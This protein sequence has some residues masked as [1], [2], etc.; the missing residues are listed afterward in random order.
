MVKGHSSLLQS[1]IKTAIDVSKNNI[2]YFNYI[3][4]NEQMLFIVFYCFFSIYSNHAQK[5]LETLQSWFLIDEKEQT[6]KSM[7]DYK[8]PLN[9]ILPWASSEF[10]QNIAK[11]INAK[12]F[13]ISLQ[14]NFVKSN[15]SRGNS[16]RDWTTIAEI[17]N[18]FKSVAQNLGKSYK[19]MIKL[20]I[21]ISIIAQCLSYFIKILEKNTDSIIS[22]S[23][24]ETLKM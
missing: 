16:K 19:V 3:E 13:R 24:Q 17:S 11:C 7:E 12:N 5:D 21:I 4:Y 9:H 8:K 23:I 15:T 22:I 10:I 6:L 1:Q 14:R 2:S 18:I 20:F